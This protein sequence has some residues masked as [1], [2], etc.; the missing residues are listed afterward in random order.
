MGLSFGVHDNAAAQKSAE[1][2]GGMSLPTGRG[3][4]R[5][6]SCGR[7]RKQESLG[8]PLGTCGDRGE[9]ASS[10]SVLLSKDSTECGNMSVNGREHRTKEKTCQYNSL[11]G[12]ERII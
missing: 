11:Y 8:K 7:A 2:E 3:A 4:E 5:V 10:I 6:K 12:N 1:T 9:A